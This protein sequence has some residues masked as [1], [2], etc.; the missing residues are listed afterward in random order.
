VL[1]GRQFAVAARWTAWSPLA[2]KALLDAANGAI[3]RPLEVSHEYV[4]RSSARDLDAPP[5]DDG[6]AL[7]QDEDVVRVI[8]IGDASRLPCDGTFPERTHGLGRIVA[9]RVEVGRRGVRVQFHVAK[10][11]RT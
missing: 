6:F 4:P 9:R 7:P 1:G 11:P 2:L 5:Y 10:N 8:R 3:A